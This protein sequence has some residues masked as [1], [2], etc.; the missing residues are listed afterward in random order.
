[1]EIRRNAADLLTYVAITCFACLE[2][3]SSAPPV[4]E[5]PRFPAAVKP[6]WHEPLTPQLPPLEEP[7]VVE[8]HLDVSYP[9]AGFLPPASRNDTPST[10]HVITQNVSHH[11]ARVYGGA[12]V[13]IRWLSIGKELRNLPES[14]RIQRDLF[15]GRST[16]LDLSIEKILSDLRSGRTEAA[17]LVTDLMATSEV[18]G[19]LVVSSQLREWLRSDQVR[20]GDFHIGLFGVKAEYWGVTHPVDCPPGPPLGCWYDERVRG[21]RR[22]ESVAH[23][24]FYVVVLGRGAEAVTSIMESIQRGI[25]EMDRPIEAEWE[26]VTSRSCGFDAVLSCKAGT[27][28]NGDER[29]R[30]YALSVDDRGQYDCVRGGRVTLFCEFDAGKDF[31]Q[32]TV[33]R[34]IW[35]SR[36]TDDL[37]IDDRDDNKGTNSV[38]SSAL[39]DGVQIR[40]A[41]LEVDIDCSAIQNALHSSAALKLNLDIVGSATRPNDPA[42]DWS[43][44]STELSAPGKTL[45]LDGFV[46]AIRVEPDRY[47]VKLPGILLFSKP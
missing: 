22:L 36:P 10:F 25:D 33:G 8:I 32:P 24:P 35:T 30:Q 9:M 12:E 43:S 20:S 46:E 47:R 2:A 31:F 17:A 27:R 23:F 6:E 16:R 38:Q 14:P 37:D 40:D 21:F 4:G 7:S 26:L 15:N 28:G 5:L 45:H 39:P 19:P 29:E 1:M 34:A 3:C 42:V 11:M 18:T 13:A 44:W 41:R